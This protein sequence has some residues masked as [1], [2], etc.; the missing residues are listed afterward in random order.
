M[1]SKSGEATPAAVLVDPVERRRRAFRAAAVAVALGWVAVIAL[2]VVG[3]TIPGA[4]RT[5]AAGPPPHRPAVTAEPTARP[6]AS[7]TVRPT[8]GP[9]VH[10]AA[11]VT[12][13]APRLS[14]RQLTET[15]KEFAT[16]PEACAPARKCANLGCKASKFGPLPGGSF[17][18]VQAAF[19]GDGAA[20]PGDASA[21]AFDCGG[22]S[23]QARQLAAE[24]FGPGDEVAVA[25]KV[26]TLPP[27]APGAPDEVAARGQVIRLSPATKPAAH[28]Y[29]CRCS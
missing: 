5:L 6:T 25:G 10:R 21:G 11:K 22:F 4:P 29:R 14:G 15:S 20:S 19:D 9:D 27:V 13:R 26:L 17:G 24:G 16:T 1:G 8:V 28:R 2:V 7:P 23:Y 3:L 18:S 12:P